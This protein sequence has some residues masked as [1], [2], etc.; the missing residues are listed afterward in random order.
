MQWFC[1]MELE[2]ILSQYNNGLLIS[3]VDSWMNNAIKK[4]KNIREKLNVSLSLDLS[5]DISILITREI[6]T[7]DQEKG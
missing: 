5:R 1:F 7:I 4:Y 2:K 3:L 6:K